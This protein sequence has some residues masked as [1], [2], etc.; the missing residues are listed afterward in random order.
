MQNKIKI[1]IADDHQTLIEALKS[2]LRA[3]G[4]EVII[5]A[6]NGKELLHQLTVSSMFP[7]L[8]IVDGNMPLMNGCETIMAL[9]SRWPTIEIIGFSL[10]KSNRHPML[11]SGASAFLLKSSPPEL[12]IDTINNLTGTVQQN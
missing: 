5:E 2:L 10:E 12:I 7:D 8:C 9:K 6:A 1:A 3:N 11:E 4:F